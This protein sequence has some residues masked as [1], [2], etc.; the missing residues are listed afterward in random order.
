MI[1]V[2]ELTEK[3]T[4]L[5]AIAT[6]NEWEELF[7]ASDLPQNFAIVQTMSKQL[8]PGSGFL[9]EQGGN[10]GVLFHIPRLS[11]FPLL[12]K[13]EHYKQEDPPLFIIKDKQ[14][15]Q[16]SPVSSIILATEFAF[17]LFEIANHTHEHNGVTKIYPQMRQQ[18]TLFCKEGDYPNKIWLHKEGNSFNLVLANE[19]KIYF[20]ASTA[21]ALHALQTSLQ[22]TNGVAVKTNGTPF[23][24]DFVLQG[25]ISDNTLSGQIILP[26]EKQPIAATFG[27][28]DE[29]DK[30]PNFS[31]L[32]SKSKKIASQLTKTEIKNLAK[33]V[34]DEITDAAYNQSD[35]TPT[36][37]DYKRLSES[38]ELTAINFYGDEAVL[39][40]ESKP[41][42]P[43]KKIFTQV[44]D[45]LGIVDVSIN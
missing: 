35:H 20:V 38:I 18:F 10:E 28:E 24:S 17:R 31:T 36:E 11:P 7:D 23:P 26:G 37:K 33:K 44:D 15:L 25:T 34:A 12:I 2:V 3:L 41:E 14:T 9:Q 22:L 43:G 21:T 39:V 45:E 8:F 16:L 6:G 13:K 40:F 30:A 19:E 32:V 1:N 4:R 5:A 42:F 27:T 29:E